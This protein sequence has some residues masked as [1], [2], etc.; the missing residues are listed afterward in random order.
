MIH[1]TNRPNLK[2]WTL[3]SITTKQ[4]G[5]LT[6]ES[7][8]LFLKDRLYQNLI[9]GRIWASTIIPDLLSKTELVPR[10]SFCLLIDFASLMIKDIE[11]QNI[12]N[13]LIRT[14]QKPNIVTSHKNC[15]FKTHNN[16]CKRCKTK[17]SNI[18]LKAVLYESREWS[19]PNFVVII[20]DI[21]RWGGHGAWWEIRSHGLVFLLPTLL[22]TSSSECLEHY[23]GQGGKKLRQ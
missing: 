1:H 16:N 11:R 21:K 17:F 7:I 10:W 12:Q 6:W 23:K 18:S 4:T 5:Y 3:K 2:S 15:S 22:P 14:R 13:T 8:E 9:H 20:R 19:D